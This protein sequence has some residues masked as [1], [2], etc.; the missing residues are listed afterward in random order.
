MRYEK[1]FLVLSFARKWN[2]RN[3]RIICVRQEK[4]FRAIRF[5]AADA[6]RSTA[7]G[8]FSPRMVDATCF[9]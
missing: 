5:L 7:D 3:F 4:F 6:A 1:I 2:D 8:D 9:L